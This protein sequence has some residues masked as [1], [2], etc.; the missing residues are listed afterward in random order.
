VEKLLKY[1]ARA[2]LENIS[3]VF[4]QFFYNLS[5]ILPQ[6][7]PAAPAGQGPAKSFYNS[8]TILPC[9]EK[10]GASGLAW[11]R[12]VEGIIVEELWKHLVNAAPAGDH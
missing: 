6:F 7:F 2:S 11:R 5:T 3:S 10:F 4:L 1:F 12:I 9:V 8:S